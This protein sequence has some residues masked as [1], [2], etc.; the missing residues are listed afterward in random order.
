MTAIERVIGELEQAA[1]YVG[2]YT[3]QGAAGLPHIRGMVDQQED[4]RARLLAMVAAA[5]AVPQ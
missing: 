4:A 3:G 5:E 1:Y 2:L